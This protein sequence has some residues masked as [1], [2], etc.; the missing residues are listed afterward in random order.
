MIRFYLFFRR[1]LAVF[2]MLGIVN[3]YAQVNPTISPA[4]FRYNTSI[5]VTY[6]VTGTPLANLTSAWAWVWTPGATVFDAKSNINPASANTT[7]TNPAKFTRSVVNLHTLFT[8]TFTPSDFF[9][10][11]ISA[12]TQM[13]ILL[14]ANDWPQG[15]TSD[16]LTTF[17]D[18]TFQTK[19]TLPTQQPLFVS[20]S[21][22]IAVAA[23]TPVTADFTLSVN[24]VALNTQTGITN[25]SFN[26]TVSDTIPFYTVTIM[27][28]TGV[29]SNS[30]SFDYVISQASTPAA[31]PPDIVDGINY[32]EDDAIVTLSLWAP[33]K[34]SAYVIGDFTNWKIN[35]DYLMKKDGEHFWLEINGLTPGVEYGFQY[36]VDETLFVADPYADKILD[37][38]DQYIPASTYPN[39]KTYP[40]KALNTKWY[41]NR[42]AV[43][44]TGQAPYS[45]QAAGYQKPAKEKLVIY[46][47]LV[48]DFFDSDHRNYQ[49]L[50]DTISYFKRLGVTAIELMPVTEFN[51][52]ESWGYNPT[53]MFAPDKYY[54]T[55]NKLKEFIDVCHQNNMAVILDIVMNQQDLPNPYVLMYYDFVTNKPT[56]N[57]PWFNVNAT[58]PFS[59]FYDLNH[60]S[61]YTKKYLDT[62]NYH[63][64]HDFKVIGLRKT[65]GQVKPQSINLKIVQPMAPETSSRNL[66][67]CAI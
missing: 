38:D 25:Y 10:Q 24:G 41:F 48:R 45:W 51:G 32:N 13:G 57:N 26:L 49:T 29:S 15:Q 4:L 5:T 60:E 59:V 14:K 2:M 39:L 42:V 9:T 46:E 27:A 37:P 35:P 65:F 52:N 31:R 36:L 55:R 28:S 30:V 53:F 67:M 19:L 11:D 62:V 23:E 6:D 66:L 17:W 18:G 54:G 12:K 58:H 22:I 33:Q 50:I 43:L 7:L 56:A 64:L 21:E 20:N 8:L 63:W 40:D 3:S 1:C 34:T 44:Q 47:L 61:P 16:F